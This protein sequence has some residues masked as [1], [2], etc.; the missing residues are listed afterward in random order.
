MVKFGEILK[1]WSLRS[2]SVTRQVSFNRTKIG[3]KCQNSNATFWVIFKQ[4]ARLLGTVGVWYFQPF[5]KPTQTTN[6]SLLS[7][8]LVRCETT[9]TQAK[10]QDSTLNSKGLKKWKNKQKVMEE[11]FSCNLLSLVLT[12]PWALICFETFAWFSIVMFFG[13]LLICL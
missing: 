10:H 13:S 4:C 7:A 2:N 12:M 3:G 5:D 1:T 8:L 11:F 9:P 6:S